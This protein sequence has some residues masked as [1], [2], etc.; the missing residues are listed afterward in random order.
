MQ[1]HVNRFRISVSAAL[2]ALVF[3]AAPAAAQS[4]SYVGMRAGYNF[5]SEEALISAHLQVPMTSRIY[6]YPSLDVY[7]P[8]SG[9]Q[10]GFS[11]DVKI[12]LPTSSNL[13]PRLYAGGGVGV[14]NR[15][16]EGLSNSDLGANILFG[17]E[18]QIGSI[19]PFAEG[20]I[21]LYDRTQFQMIAGVSLI[22][23]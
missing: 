13:G 22:L 21:M 14:T 15:N 16:E 23:R 12:G 1:L 10:I 6:F 7:M 2:M 18:S 9:N 3:T 20:K 19:R 8:E 11:G 5:G 4:N 17:V